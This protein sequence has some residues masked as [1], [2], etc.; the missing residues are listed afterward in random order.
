M[1]KIFTMRRV[2][3]RWSPK[4]G[5]LPIGAGY[6]VGLCSVYNYL[7]CPGH[8]DRAAQ[9]GSYVGSRSFKDIQ[10]LT[11]RTGIYNFLLVTNSNSAFQVIET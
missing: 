9:V 4:C 1:R 5:S 2:G 11:N 10:F 3:G 8:G 6:L 7:H